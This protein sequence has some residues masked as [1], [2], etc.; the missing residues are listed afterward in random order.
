MEPLLFT[1]F[2]SP[3]KGLVVDYLS[4]FQRRNPGIRFRYKEFDS[5]SS[6]CTALSHGKARFSIGETQD[7]NCHSGVNDKI[8]WT[9][10]LYELSN[11]QRGVIRTVYYSPREINRATLEQ[12][13]PDVVIKGADDNKQVL[14]VLLSQGDAI[15]VTSLINAE[16]LMEEYPET[17]ASNQ[18]REPLTVRYYLGSSSHNDV[19]FVRGISKFIDKLRSNAPNRFELRWFNYARFYNKSTLSLSPQQMDWIRH[20]PVIKVAVPRYAY[21]LGYIDDNG[22]FQGISAE[23]LKIV[24]KETGID[25]QPVP[26]HN[27][28]EMIEY[29]R[30]GKADIGAHRTSGNEKDGVIISNPMFISRYV[31]IVRKDSKI[32][33]ALKSFDNKRL[34]F[35]RGQ[36]V[37]P[38]ISNKIHA[39][40][41]SKT[42]GAML[43][44]LNMVSDNQADAIIMPEIIAPYWIENY[45]SDSLKS[46]PLAIEPAVI[47]YPI[48]TDYGVLQQIINDVLAERPYHFLRSV[49]DYWTEG[50]SPPTSLLPNVTIIISVSVVSAVI[51]TLIFSLFLYR[52]KLA[53]HKRKVLESHSQTL[54]LILNATPFPIYISDADGN[55]KFKNKFLQNLMDNMDSNYSRSDSLNSLF[56]FDTYKIEALYKKSLKIRREVIE[57]DVYT[58]NEHNV[59]LK[60]W[61]IPLCLEEYQGYD[62]IGGW[63]DLTEMERL[64]RELR[65]EKGQALNYAAEKN[66]FLAK[67]SHDIRTPLS[68]I[69]G[70]VEIIE[71]KSKTISRASLKS[72]AGMVYRNISILLELLDQLLDYSKADEKES[73]MQ[74]ITK[75]LN[76]REFIKETVEPFKMK[77][78]SSD[79]KLLTSFSL[80]LDDYFLFDY[81]KLRQVLNNLL[82]NAIKFTA[83]GSISVVANVSDIDSERSLMELSVT[84]TGIGITD[85]QSGQLFKVFT[86]ASENTSEVYGGYG[87]G[88]AI[89]KQ[90]CL[91]M[92]GDIVLNSQYG[93][94]TSIIITLPLKKSSAESESAAEAFICDDF[95]MLRVAIIE[96]NAAS[97]F[98]LKAQLEEFGVSVIEPGALDELAATIKKQR[99]D[100]VIC[101]YELNGFS[102][103][104]VLAFINQKLL[105]PPPCYI[106]TANACDVVHSECMHA[107]AASVLRKPCSMTQ[108]NNVLLEV[109]SYQSTYQLLTCMEKRAGESRETLSKMIDILHES[110]LA[111]FL[112]LKYSYPHDYSSVFKYIHSIKGV[113]AIL[114]YDQLVAQCNEFT[115]ALTL[116]SDDAGEQW[117]HLEAEL[118]KLLNIIEVGRTLLKENMLYNNFHPIQ[119]T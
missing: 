92:G 58:L 3:P 101:D 43:N 1:E 118:E 87:L 98:L 102:A 52:W 110:M 12:I 81:L 51:A 82:S 19:R 23:I 59:Y 74:G 21:P 93:S 9:S 62:I 112:G 111:D 77:T 113:L 50:V 97:R 119:T 14:D 30:E 2:N 70:I 5:L 28:G 24:A 17:L 73:S 104:D 96:D 68:V 55:F 41:I 33:G 106:Y 32:T 88:L 56:P 36:T 91:A 94:G 39:S 78:A 67:I 115:N 71:K 83:Q 4:K 116:D 114:H 69:I 84:D 27:V 31:A 20:H 25:F 26:V 6:L 18:T 95:S 117:E 45:Y 47:V 109:R 40:T 60:Y 46:V 13:Y 16:R 29:I 38:F 99:V 90:L 22:A 85:E 11:K 108:M 8:I 54:E 72:Q 34:V 63:I 15:F 37:M 48:R 76:I 107:G 105:L 44:A 100:A 89:C 103:I 80:N 49:D 66:L 7:Y 53:K 86:Q 35:T 75:S 10:S 65:E 42:Q 64:Q 79:V 61:L 57:Q